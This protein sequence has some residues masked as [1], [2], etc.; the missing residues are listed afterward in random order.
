MLVIGRRP[1]QYVVINNNIK[2]KVVKSDSGDLRLAIDAPSDIK[3]I[4][5]E[6]YETEVLKKA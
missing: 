6:I 4:R 1:G 5:G 3:I 2:V